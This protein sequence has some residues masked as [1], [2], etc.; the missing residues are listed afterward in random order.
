ML[1]EDLTRGQ[2]LTSA[3]V[4]AGGANVTGANVVS[5]GNKYIG[6][7][8]LPGGKPFAAGTKLTIKAS[9]LAGA[10]LKRASFYN[11]SRAPAASG[12]SYQ[13]DFAYK[14]V[15]S[16]TIATLKVCTSTFLRIRA[17]NSLSR[18]ACC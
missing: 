9:G 15:K 18:V 1:Q 3:T 6:F 4:S 2:R 12:C 11:C 10:K 7:L 5:V 17:V 8:Q 14:V 13:K 16:I